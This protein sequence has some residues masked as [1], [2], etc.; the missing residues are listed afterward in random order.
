MLT[1][2]PTAS[3][4]TAKAV[5]PVLGQH[6]QP[7]ASILDEILDVVHR[8]HVSA[9]LFNLLHAPEKPQRCI[10]GLFGWHP[11][12]QVL[13]DLALQMKLKLV[14]ELLLFLASPEEG[15]D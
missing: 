12:R 15:T 6:P 10:T 4:K 8:A 5:K 2:I 1:A 3:A 11:R 13:V 7:E 9:L 14:V